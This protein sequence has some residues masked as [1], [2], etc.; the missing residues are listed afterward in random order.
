MK[1]KN[2]LSKCTN[3]VLF[4]NVQDTLGLQ[5]SVVDK[6]SKCNMSFENKFQNNAFSN[7]MEPKNY[8]SQ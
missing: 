1:Q 6:M 5:D 3:Y 4:R 2:Y 8:L 7:S